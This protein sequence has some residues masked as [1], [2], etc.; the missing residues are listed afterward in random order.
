MTYRTLLTFTPDHP[1]TRNLTGDAHTAHQMVMSGFAHLLP[2]HDLFT[3]ADGHHPDHRANLNILQ[4]TQARPNGDIQLLIQ[5]DQPG[6]WDQQDWTTALT[7][8]PRTTS[9]TIATTG[10]IRYQLTCNPTWR[11]RKTRKTLAYRRPEG[12][13]EWWAKRASKIGLTLNDPGR[14][15]RTDTLHSPR[16]K[17]LRIDTATLVGVAEV[18]DPVALGEAITGGVGRAKA[19]GCGLLITQQAR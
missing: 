7:T 9:P 3:G 5:S 8:T 16:K 15:L 6:T 11:S 13:L 1:A 17:G 2:E 18:A 14:V 12:I 10:T 4:A 19:Y